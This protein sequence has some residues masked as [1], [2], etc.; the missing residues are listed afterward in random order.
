MDTLT[1]YAGPTN[2]I[3]L[4][5]T[6]GGD[7]QSL[8]AVTRWQFTIGATTLDSD[9]TPALFDWT[10]SATTLTIDLSGV[11]DGRYDS[12]TLTYFDA[13][14]PTGAV[15]TDSIT[16]F[17][18]VTPQGI[19]VQELFDR[20]LGRLAKTPAV[21]L[22]IVDMVNAV[23]PVI[24][25]RLQYLAMD[26]LEAETTISFTAN[27]GARAL[28][29]GFR[30]IIGNPYIAADNF[31]LQPLN[32]SRAV[33]AGETGA[34]V[35]YEV[36]GSYLHLYP[37]PDETVAVTLTFSQE[38]DK[39]ENMTD[40]LP[41]NAMFDEVYTEGVLRIAA[42]G[43]TALVADPQFMAVLGNAVDAYHATRQQQIADAIN[44]G[45]SFF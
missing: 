2:S 33:Y 24:A 40:Y 39:V 1:V 3:S 14:A 18:G 45:V 31:Q 23:T 41:Y 26:L 6:T 35:R 25:R 42:S 9:T 15:W 5:L 32:C 16:V 34:P 44:R 22:S 19:T 13:S 8:A 27:I 43:S 30:G 4:Q 38:P 20:L 28:P 7:A 37:T 10:T 11:N 21:G 17:I 36:R 12:C 29:S